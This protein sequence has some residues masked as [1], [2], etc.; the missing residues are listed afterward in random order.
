[1]HTEINE[2]NTVQNFTPLPKQEVF[3]YHVLYNEIAKFIWYCGGFGSGKTFIGSQTAIR[4]AMMAPNGRGLIGRNTL[5][6]LKATTMKTFFEVVDRRLI[7]SF[8]KSENLLTLTNGHEIYFWGLDDIEK[9]KSLEIGWFWFDEVDEVQQ[10]AFE[11]AQGRLRHKAQ[12]KRIGMITSN[13]EGKN[14]TYK[15]FIRGEGVRSEADL[16]KYFVIKAPSDENTNLPEDYLEVLNSYTGDLYER[17]VRASF[18]VFEGQIF[19]EFRR[20]IHVIKPFAI[21]EE[22]ER[23]RAIDHGE[24]NPTACGWYAIT[25]AGDV[26]KYREHYEG[27]QYVKHHAKIVGEASEGEK[28]SY[29]VIDPSTRST[30]GASGKKIDQEWKDEMRNYEKEFRLRYGVNSVNAGI[31]RMHRYLTIDPEKKH[32]FTGKMGSPRMFYFD[33]CPISI[34]EL[35]TYKWSKIRVA[36]EDDPI[37]KPRKR[38]D[39]S[40]DEN[41]YAVMSR[42]LAEMG[43]VHSSLRTNYLSLKPRQREQLLPTI[44]EEQIIEQLKKENPGDFLI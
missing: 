23:F 39:H 20:D 21:P 9:L 40:V 28:I 5:V 42:P 44:T 7:R 4:L 24:R 37:E 25:P 22:W 32:P 15:K 34:D 17:Y 18:E 16:S 8:N 2:S 31:A 30:R 26:I 6:D 38:D 19:K 1:M 14:W 12:P 36:N 29:T 3:M 10:I 41:R 13:S 35:E 11:V 43:S 33:T 27:G